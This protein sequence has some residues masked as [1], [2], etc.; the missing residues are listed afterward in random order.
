M[1]L[2]RLVVADRANASAVGAALLALPLGIDLPTGMKLGLL[3]LSFG[4]IALAGPVSALMVVCLALPFSSC[5]FVIGSSEWSPLELA[6]LTCAAA[7]GLGGL[8]EVLAS[9][10][11]SPLWRMIWPFDLVL[12]AGAILILSVASIT[13]VADTDLRPDSLRSLRRVIIEPLFVVPA[14]ADIRRR[15]MERIL[16]PWLAFPALAVSIL[17]IVQTI[18]GRSTVDIGGIERPIGTFTH[19]NNLAFYLERAIWFTP[20]LALP[21]I[22]R[23]G[24]L[25]WLIPIAVAIAT[26]ATVSRGAAVALGVGAV[27]LFWEDVRRRWRLAAGVAVAGA[28]LVFVSRYF[29]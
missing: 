24:R 26:L 29:A 11:L 15:G 25:A 20:L 16:V 17:A 4:V 12:L 2:A 19:P 3:A 13:W 10:S 27:V 8:R 9:R 21:L 28:F 22:H 7:V 18:S 1:T 23:H 5:V 14:L 6:L